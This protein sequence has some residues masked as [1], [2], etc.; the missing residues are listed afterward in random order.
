M[1]PV[2]AK[3]QPCFELPNHLILN[4]LFKKEEIVR[5]ITPELKD[6]DENHDLHYTKDFLPR[7]HNLITDKS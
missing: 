2:F 3:V 4:M 7:I 6:L 5:K 1:I